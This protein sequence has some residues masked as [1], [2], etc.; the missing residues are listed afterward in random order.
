[1]DLGRS[2]LVG[3]LL[4]HDSIGWELRNRSRAAA[5]GNQRGVDGDRTVP[6][7]GGSYVALPPFMSYRRFAEADER[8]AAR[9]S[10]QPEAIDQIDLGLPIGRGEAGSFHATSDKGCRGACKPAFGPTGI[11]RAAHERI[12]S[13]LARKLNLPVPAVCL[14][15]NPV[16]GELFSISA[17][18]FAQAPL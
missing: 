2:L 9:W 8:I 15:T 1:M 3:H 4:G 17:W 10:N 5:S 14:W 16:T 6:E 11:A 18:A 12:A 13:D 7:G